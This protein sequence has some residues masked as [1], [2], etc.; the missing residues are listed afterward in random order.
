VNPEFVAA[1]NDV[2]FD[3]SEK[4]LASVVQQGKRQRFRVRVHPSANE[5]SDNLFAVH[6]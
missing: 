5:V 6:S 1:L 3:A 2:L 4:P